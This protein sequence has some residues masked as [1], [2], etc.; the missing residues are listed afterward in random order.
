M[1]VVKTLETGVDYTIQTP[2]AASGGTTAPATGDANYTLFF[3]DGIVFSFPKTSQGCIKGDAT[4]ADN[5]CKG[6]ID[7]NG[8]KGPN[9][10]VAC[11][12]TTNTADCVVSNPT[13]VYPVMFYNQ[14]VL[15]NSNAARA[16]LYGK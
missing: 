13:D 12:G 14:T 3:N 9:K 4:A 1:N 15:P 16:V 8:Q 2:T 11:D 7:V 5:I 10:V 6:I